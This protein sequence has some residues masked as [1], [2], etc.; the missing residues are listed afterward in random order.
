M[1][2]ILRSRIGIGI[3][4]IMLIAAC[5][6]TRVTSVWKDPGYRGSPD[7]IMVI[8]VAKRPGIKRIFE[9]EFV[10]QLRARGNDAIASYTVLPDDKQGDET[11]IAAKM[12]GQ[13]SDAVLITRM[14]SKKTVQSYVQTPGSIYPYPYPPYPPYFSTWRHYYGYG[15][16]AMYA[17]GYLAEDEYAVME[18][19]L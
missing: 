16:Q 14:V 18:T 12:K 10:R 1:K 9:D 13:D 6:T 2:R 5:S 3:L 19:N 8:G 15:Y 7:K 11:A 4:I 17:P